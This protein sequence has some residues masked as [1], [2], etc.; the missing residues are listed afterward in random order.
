MTLTQTAV[1]TK[2]AIVIFAIGLFLLVSG[3]IGWEFY[4]RYTLSKLPPPQEI[5]EAKFGTLPELQF[6]QGT[7]SSANFSYSVDTTTGELPDF[8]SLIEVYFIP[9]AGLSL[10]APDRAKTLAEKLNFN[11]GPENPSP[12]VYR[13]MSENGGDL[14]IDTP[15]G[16]FNFKLGPNEA[17]A[18][19]TLKLPEKP[20]I[21]DLFK[22]FLSDNLSLPEILSAGRG[23]VF[24]SESSPIT[25]TVTLI[26]EDFNN[27]PIVTSIYNQGLVKADFIATEEENRIIFTKLSYVFWPIDESTSSTYKL[28]TSVQALSDLKSGKAYV[29]LVPENPNVSITSVKLAYFE[30]EEYIP[31]LQPVFVFEGPSFVALVPAILQ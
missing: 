12:E 10:L 6:P 18:S 8:P 31:Y 21:I 13:F 22:R 29:S 30:T 14:V 24:L 23:E 2:R 28:K 19:S 15:T 9:Q 16:N 25:G 5:A 27:L 7:T 20:V 3:K 4:Y 26:P 11:I 1:L 17:T